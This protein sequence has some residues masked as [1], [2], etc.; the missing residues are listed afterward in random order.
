MLPCCHVLSARL[1]LAP[2]AAC[3]PSAAFIPSLR[4]WLGAGFHTAQSESRRV[5]DDVN[6]QSGVRR[7]R[8]QPKPIRILSVRA[9]AVMV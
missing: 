3:D 7:M 1:F 4:E 5:D 9:A 2:D 6:D 8:R